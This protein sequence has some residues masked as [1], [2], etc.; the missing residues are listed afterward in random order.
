MKWLLSLFIALIIYLP[1]SVDAL[2]Y[3]YDITGKLP[4]TFYDV[5]FDLSSAGAGYAIFDIRTSSEQRTGVAISAVPTH[6]WM[7]ARTDN[8]GELHLVVVTASA[9][10]ATVVGLK[11]QP[12]IPPDNEMYA[13][14][15]SFFV[16]SLTGIAFVVASSSMNEGHII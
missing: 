1:V 15:L 16:G 11:A 10:V 4:E 9:R 3:R 7:T 6:Y 14:V 2:E 8:L 12:Y 5:F 13:K